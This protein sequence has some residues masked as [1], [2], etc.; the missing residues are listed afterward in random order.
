MG[1]KIGDANTALEF[2][3]DKKWI[4]FNFTNDGFPSFL[5]EN[6]FKPSTKKN[7][8][9]EVAIF[10]L[11][12]NGNKNM[13]FWY[14]FKDT[15][16]NRKLFEEAFILFNGKALPKNWEDALV[17]LREYIVNSFYIEDNFLCGKAVLLSPN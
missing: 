13:S 17:K 8:E 6:V 9:F 10:P 14:R 15:K 1:L 11:S 16:T 3:I 12:I 2:L 7:A 5:E 4:I